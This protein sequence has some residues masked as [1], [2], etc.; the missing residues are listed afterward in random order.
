MT[1]FQKLAVVT[2]ATAILLVTVGVIVRATD[3]GLGCP[4]WPTCYGQLIPPLDDPKAWI[5]WIH[6]T[7]A[8][9]IGF[10]IL[11][12]AALAVIDHRDRRSILVAGARRR[13]PGRLPGVARPRDRPARQ[14]RGVGDGAPHRRDAARRAARLPARSV[15]ASRPGFAGRG[16]S[17]R[18]TLLAAFTA[19]ATFALLLFGSNVTATDAGLVFPDWPLMNG[20]LAPPLTE[21][22]LG[23]RPAPMG[24]GRGRGHRGGDRRRRVADP[25][26]TDRTSSA[27]AVGAAVL[28]AIQVVIGG[29]QVLTQ[30]AAWTQTLHLALGAVIWALLVGLAVLSWC[31]ARSEVVEVPRRRL[32]SDGAR[33]RGATDAGG[34]GTRDPRRL[35]PRL[36]RPDQAADHRAAARHHGPGD[37][38]RHAVRARAS[39]GSSGAGS[40][41]W[42]LIGGT[43]AAGSANAINCYLDR[44]I[45]ELMTRTRRRPLPAHEV[46]PERAVIFGLVAR[47][48]L[49]RRH[50]RRSST[51][52]RRS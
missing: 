32:A 37:G 22:T 29:L 40:S 51:C 6:R 8:A 11:G 10:Q 28:Y 47:R 9:V 2:L 21:V 12:L 25:A 48:H 41:L 23:A 7:I 13:R 42:T 49:V 17:Q 31:A 16:G 36:H 18:F 43:L 26:R 33:R 14:Q 20:T 1:R 46:E 15:P 34:R 44:D 50:G 5:E 39:T 52:W 38:P 45:D 30:L 3:S 27:C 19:L 4:D 35:G 24:R